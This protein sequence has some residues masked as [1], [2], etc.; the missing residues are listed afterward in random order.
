[1]YQE[2][3]GL[4]LNQYKSTGGPSAINIVTITDS[5][6]CCTLALSDFNIV[7]TNNT[8]L[9]T[10]NG[11]ITIT[12]PVLTIADYEASIDAGDNWV[13]QVGGRTIRIWMF[14]II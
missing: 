4:D 12:A 5:P 7:R 8:S 1:M 2:C 14:G 11:T 6:S 3:D 13:T 9:I 10:P